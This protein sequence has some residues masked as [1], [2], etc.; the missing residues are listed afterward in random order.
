MV[1][2]YVELRKINIVGIPTIRYN[3]IDWKWQDAFISV[4]TVLPDYE[5]AEGT[6]LKKKKMTKEEA[7]NIYKKVALLHNTTVDEVKRQIKL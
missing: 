6:D 5:V 4:K 3:M 2:L 7:E 1:K